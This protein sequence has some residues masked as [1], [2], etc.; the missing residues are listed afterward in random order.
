[1]PPSVRASYFDSLRPKTNADEFERA[2][3]ERNLHFLVDGEMP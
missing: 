1:M 3:Y 2:A